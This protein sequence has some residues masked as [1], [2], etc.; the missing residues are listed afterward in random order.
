MGVQIFFLFLFFHFYF[1]QLLKETTVSNCLAQSVASLTA[2]TEIASS[3]PAG[4]HYFSGDWSGNNF[5]SYSPPSP[6]L[7]RVVVSSKWKY[8]HKVLVYC[9]VNLA[10]EKSGARWFDR[11]DMTIAVD[12]DV[13]PQTKQKTKTSESMAN[14]HPIAAQGAVR[15][16]S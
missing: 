12:W 8:V 2:D 10:Q 13:K 6:D 9:L 16:Q 4:S 15:K 1:L 3:I 5:Y 14:S 11:L 7:R